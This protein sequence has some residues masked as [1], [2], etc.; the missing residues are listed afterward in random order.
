MADPNNQEKTMGNQ[1][2]KTKEPAPKY[3]EE[4]EPKYKP[5][6]VVP[7]MVS[8][9]IIITLCQAGQTL[10]I[11]GVTGTGLSGTKVE[12]FRGN[13]KVAELQ[14]PV[15]ANGTFDGSVPNSGF[16]AGDTVIVRI[17]G[18]VASCIAK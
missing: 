14:N 6:V 12:I 4:P 18:H 3:T 10:G 8:G 15:D 1:T 2:Y 9:S 5:K 7:D 17:G 13:T 11:A 16:K